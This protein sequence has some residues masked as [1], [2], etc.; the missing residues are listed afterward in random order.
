[1]IRSLV[2]G[3]AL[4]LPALALA[5]PYGN[6]KDCPYTPGSETHAA[7]NAPA[8]DA[9]TANADPAGCAHASGLVGSNCSFTTGAMAQNV[10]DHGT[11]WTFTGSLSASANAL[12]SHVAAPYTVGPQPV[13]VVANEVLESLTSAGVAANRVALEGR[14]LEVD[15]VKYFVLTTWHNLN[16]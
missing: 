8:A 11:P 1:M 14:L 7:V 6:T 10:L 4:M 3:V 12:P 2:V 13:Q 15:G 9:P 5:C 16:S